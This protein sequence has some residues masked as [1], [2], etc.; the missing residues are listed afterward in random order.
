MTRDL[1]CL[2]VE[3]SEGLNNEATC[4]IN[5]YARVILSNKIKILQ[6]NPAKT[7]K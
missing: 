2:Y 3:T 5:E 1:T 6:N 7:E 4:S